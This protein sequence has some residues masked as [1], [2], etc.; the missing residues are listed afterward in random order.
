VGRRVKRAACSAIVV[1]L[2]LLAVQF[3][4]AK[5]HARM[6]L[7]IPY[8]VFNSAEPFCYEME[9]AHRKFEAKITLNITF[10]ER[11]NNAVVLSF[12]DTNFS[13]KRGIALKIYQWPM[14]VFYVECG[15][16]ETLVATVLGSEGGWR[17]RVGNIL[18]MAFDGERFYIGNTSDKGLI[19]NGFPLGED[20]VL[21]HI[22]ASGNTNTLTAGFVVVEFEEVEV[23]KQSWSSLFI[24]LILMLVL[25]VFWAVLPIGFL[26]I[27]VLLM[28]LLLLAS[29]IQPFIARHY[30]KP[31]V[32]KDTES[33]IVIMTYS[34]PENVLE[35]CTTIRGNETKQ[36]WVRNWLNLAKQMGFKG[37]GVAELECY[38]LDGY[39]DEYLRLIGEY[40]LK[41]ALY[42]MW[43][44]F[45][46]N[47]CFAQNA[48]RPIPNEFWM[49]KDFPDNTA[50]VSAWLSFI[51]DVTEIAKNHSNV[52]FYLLFMPFR[53]QN[54][55]STQANFENY[56]EYRRCMQKAVNTI[57]R[58]DPSRPVLLV[59]DGIEM[60]DL[61]LVQLG[62]IPYDLENIDGYG[63]TYY[64]RA[65]NCFCCPHFQWIVEFYSRKIDEFLDGKGYLFLAE[66]GWQTNNI[67][68]YGYCHSEARKCE[69][70]KETVKAIADLRIK[71]WGYFSMQDFPPENAT[72]GLAYPNYTLKPSGEV[73]QK[74]L[75]GK[76]A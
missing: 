67:G 5:V 54:N 8:S 56:S 41:A 36:G 40:G 1:V 60:E 4:T 76:P 34:Q 13:S 2:F 49:P 47:V 70:V 25:A 17:S 52:E 44:D 35:R 43:R 62:R 20:W 21:S 51:K 37:V 64:S 61:T 63:F 29:L 74:L 18:C 75:K 73:M 53:W 27:F 55:A 58:V 57:K 39:L 48:S 45:T 31:L 9:D 24:A 46:I 28:I 33:Y 10:V 72:F 3:S 23:A 38:Y 71:Y 7:S 12:F 30:A 6:K 14:D 19:L 66:W 16:N 11:T 65:E 15:S 22:Q 50:K 69:L 26:R 32:I 59:S 42:I 68:V